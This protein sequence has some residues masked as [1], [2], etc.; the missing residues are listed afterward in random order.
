MKKY[1][2]NP[3]LQFIIFMVVIFSLAQFISSTNLYVK[4]IDINDLPN[5]DSIIYKIEE[6]RDQGSYFEILGYAFDVNNRYKYTNYITGTGENL[7][8][9]IKLVLIENG[10]S[11]ILNTTP[12][13]SNEAGTLGS[14]NL[15]Y[16]G[17][18]AKFDKSEISINEAKI[19][20]LSQDINGNKS[21][22]ITKEVIYYE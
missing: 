9:N 8:V 5:S 15:H 19:A 17:F 14:I 3:F 22:L 2:L 1:L 20:I 4:S 6:I 10:K 12:R 7:Y 16:F 11:I 13:Y 21:I 18:M